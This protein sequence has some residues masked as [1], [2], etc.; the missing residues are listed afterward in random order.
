MF[1]FFSSYVKKLSQLLPAPHELL[2]A[3]EFTSNQMIKI[4]LNI[5]DYQMTK[6]LLKMRDVYIK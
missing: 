3:L 6:I 5:R 2:S 1:P 4:F